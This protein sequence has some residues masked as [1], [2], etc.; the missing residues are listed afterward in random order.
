[1][2]RQIPYE[3]KEEALR[4]SETFFPVCFLD[5]AWSVAIGRA[6]A[7][8]ERNQDSQDEPVLLWSTPGCGVKMKVV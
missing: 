8:T 5:I 6:D 1:M 7:A 3:H 4:L 2:F